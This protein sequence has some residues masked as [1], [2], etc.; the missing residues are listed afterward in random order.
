MKI[1]RRASAAADALE[2]F[3]HDGVVARA[4][5]L[6]VDDGLPLARPPVVDDEHA[7]EVHAHAVVRVG[8]EDVRP[9]H[10]GQGA[11]PPD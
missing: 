10:E 8:R 3:H 6:L 5:I 4:D 1:T 2:V 11:R 7:V 9:V